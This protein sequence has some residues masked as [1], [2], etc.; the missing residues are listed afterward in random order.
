[1]SKGRFEPSHA[2]AL[3]LKEDEVQHFVSYAADSY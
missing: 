1:M 3:M 2:L